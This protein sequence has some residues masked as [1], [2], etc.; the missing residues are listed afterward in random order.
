MDKE[1]MKLTFTSFK[2]SQDLDGLKVSIDRHPPKLCSYP[3]LSYMIMPK[4][5]NLSPTNMERI[6]HSILDNNWE[7]VQDFVSEIYRL[8]IHQI[9]FCDWCTKEQII[10]GKFCAAGI[11]GKYI[12]D[13]A[14][15][16]G[17]FEFSIELEYKD[18]RD[19]L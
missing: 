16:D 14:D 19:A 10:H 15:G 1:P 3:V 17:K 11:V 5:D 4:V 2:D 9:I 6:C 18:G 8:G 7:L 12:R 13:K